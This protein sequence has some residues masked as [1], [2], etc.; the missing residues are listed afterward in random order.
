MTE[1]VVHENPERPARIREKTGE[2]TA[3]EI[4]A[5]TWTIDEDGTL[6]LPPPA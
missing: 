4:A 3:A 6:H 5:R 2:R 1:P